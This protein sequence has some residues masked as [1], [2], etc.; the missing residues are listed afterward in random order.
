MAYEYANLL[1]AWIKQSG[2][3]SHTFFPPSELRSLLR[4]VVNQRFR[5]AGFSVEGYNG[6]LKK[7][8]NYVTRNQHTLKNYRQFLPLLPPAELHPHFIVLQVLREGGA[9]NVFDS[10][11][12][13]LV[14]V[15]PNQTSAK[16]R[17]EIAKD[18]GGVLVKFTWGEDHLKCPFEIKS[19]P[20]QALFD[21]WSC[22]YFALQTIV[23]LA[24]NP[25]LDW[26]SDEGFRG[27]D[28]KDLFLTS[29]LEGHI[30]VTR[31]ASITSEMHKLHVYC[32]N[33]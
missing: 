30:D 24:T 17:N 6:A 20:Q 12:D 19:T 22:G 33:N 2:K 29:I 7:V 1:C 25:D 5:K 28:L 16:I 8:Q 10:L 3:S 9:C 13:F 14:E 23:Q 11:H 18:V 32:S 31:L 21:G 4:G 26:K 15:V 27:A